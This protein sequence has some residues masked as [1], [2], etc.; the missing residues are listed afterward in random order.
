MTIDSRPDPAASS[1]FAA[2]STA[3]LLIITGLSGAGRTSLLKSVEDLGYETIDNMPVRLVAPAVEAMAPGD[4][5]AIGIDVRT[6]GFDVAAVEQSL[7]QIARVP[8]L[9]TTMVY[10]DCDD[11]VLYR[12]YTETR[13]RHPL[14][15]ADDR[16]VEDGIRDERAL[17][18]P[19]RDRADVVLDTSEFSLTDLRRRAAELFA[20]G[21]SPGLQLAVTSFG[22]RRGLPRDA[23][24][25]LDVRFLSNPHYDPLLRPLT[26]LDAAV[27]AH[28]AADPLFGAF[29]DRSLDLIR[30]LLPAYAREGKSYLTIAIGCTGGQHRSV[31]VTE[32][33]AEQLRRDG[34]RVTVRH[35]DL[36]EPGGLRPVPPGTQHRS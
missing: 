2:A 20:F 27:G 17:I 23:D 8:G 31:F 9:V 7:A 12:R 25:V 16:P 6:R 28:V 19:L 3:R 10:L 32:R 22:F 35:R 11:E 34:W 5:L 24:L 14:S 30:L 15:A 21:G 29:F 1:A 4:A 36:P 26:G 33:L 13:R 18:Q